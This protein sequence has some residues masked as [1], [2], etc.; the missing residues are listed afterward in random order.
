MSSLNNKRRIDA[1]RPSGKRQHAAAADGDNSTGGSRAYSLA[2]ISSS[3]LK[4][5]DNSFNWRHQDTDVDA[6]CCNRCHQKFA[7]LTSLGRR[8]KVLRM[9]VVGEIFSQSH[10]IT[11]FCDFCVEECQPLLLVN[12]KFDESKHCVVCLRTD[13]PMVLT[14]IRYS[15]ASTPT[16]PI[17]IAICQACHQQPYVKKQLVGLVYRNNMPE[18]ALAEV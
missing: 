5:K 2:D 3:R 10:M 4:I 11:Y 7:I 6:L 15:R 14:P 13:C 1:K 8:K 12:E 18:N 17:T 9:H 16:K